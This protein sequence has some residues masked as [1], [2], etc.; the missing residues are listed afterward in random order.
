M[1]D[2]KFLSIQRQYYRPI[3]TLPLLNKRGAIP[4]MQWSERDEKKET[5]RIGV[6][7]V[8]V[9][10]CVKRFQFRSHSHRFSS[11]ITSKTCRQDMISG[12]I[13]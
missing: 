10:Q 4:P 12:K 13:S 8:F 1:Y 11:L 5:E 6:I 2:A 9:M 3:N 7:V